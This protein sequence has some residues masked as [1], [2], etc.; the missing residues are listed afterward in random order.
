MDGYEPASESATN[1]ESTIDG[2][3]KGIYHYCVLTF[4]VASLKF[5]IF[6]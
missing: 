1:P 5:K 3:V 6:V 4:G 2:D